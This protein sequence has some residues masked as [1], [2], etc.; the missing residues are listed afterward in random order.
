MANGRK[1]VVKRRPRPIA[2]EAALERM[3]KR[4]DDLLDHEVSLSREEQ[5]ELELL[6]NLVRA[7]E[8][9]HFPVLPFGNREILAYLL[10][11][12]GIDMRQLAAATKIRYQTWSNIFRGTEKMS[13][14][15]IAKA[16]KYFRVKQSLFAGNDGN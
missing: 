16:A 7:Y 2:S 8:R 10:E 5:N 1:A 14:S 12:K 13:A 15:A 9:K 4:I 6:S 11:M 3:I